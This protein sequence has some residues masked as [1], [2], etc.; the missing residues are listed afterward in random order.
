MVKGFH[1]VR[2]KPCKAGFRSHH[3]YLKGLL[4]RLLGS[5][6]GQGS[7]QALF[8]TGRWLVCSLGGYFLR[9]SVLLLQGAV[10]LHSAVQEKTP[11]ALRTQ[12]AQRRP[13]CP[14]GLSMP[15]EDPSGLGMYGEEPSNPQDLAWLEISRAI[16]A[17]VQEWQMQRTPLEASP[18]YYIVPVLF[19]RNCFHLFLKEEETKVWCHFILT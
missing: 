17:L 16:R 8:S 10:D 7:M 9:N 12:H 6:T 5:Q 2:V 11:V 3:Y 1:Q 18:R 4:V 19:S 15:G 13:P 14:S